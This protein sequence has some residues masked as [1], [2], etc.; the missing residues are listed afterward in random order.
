M[1]WMAPDP[2]ELEPPSPTSP[3]L[4]FQRAPR[5]STADRVTSNGLQTLRRANKQLQVEIQCNSG[6]WDEDD[7]LDPQSTIRAKP[8]SAER[9]SRSPDDEV[10]VFEVQRQQG[11]DPSAQRLNDDSLPNNIASP[12]IAPANQGEGVRTRPLISPLQS[13]TRDPRSLFGSPSQETHLPWVRKLSNGQFSMTVSPKLLPRDAPPPKSIWDAEEEEFDRWPTAVEARAELDTVRI[14]ATTKRSTFIRLEEPELSV[15]EQIAEAVDTPL[16]QHVR[17]DDEEKQMIFELED[18][19]CGNPCG[20]DLHDTIIAPLREDYTLLSKRAPARH[21]HVLDAKAY[22]SSTDPV[23]KA[24]RP[25]LCDAIATVLAYTN[26]E[27]LREFLDPEI[28]VFEWRRN[29]NCVLIRREG[30]EVVVGNYYNFG[31]MYQW[32]FLVRSTI[33]SDGAWSETWASVS[34][35]TTPVGQEGVLYDRFEADGTGWDVKPDD[36]EF[37]L[38]VGRD[39]AHFLLRWEVWNYHKWWR[40]QIEWESDGKVTRARDKHRFPAGLTFD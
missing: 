4:T 33:D 39:L 9:W 37:A 24:A 35:G 22:T 25:R 10:D 36:E 11:S 1:S 34:Q 23:M 20:R 14:N 30:K 21:M 17:T 38:Y 29:N 32:G 3:K 27:C 19:D 28:E 18:M 6:L 12:D 31:T 15:A 7:D 8:E 13:P 2:F 16:G 40:Y 5:T 26:E